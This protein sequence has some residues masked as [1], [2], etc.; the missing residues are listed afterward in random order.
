MTKT[1]AVLLAAVFLA[2][3]GDS[4][5]EMKDILLTDIVSL[6]DLPGDDGCVPGTHKPG[7]DGFPGVCEDA[8]PYY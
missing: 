7:K 6:R 3:C 2:G 1:K 8:T 5:V 4:A